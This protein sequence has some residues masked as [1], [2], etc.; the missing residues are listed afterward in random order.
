MSLVEL[1][2]HARQQSPPSEFKYFNRLASA[3]DPVAASIFL[4]IMQDVF[5]QQLE[6]T[7]EER[8]GIK[9]KSQEEL[10]SFFAVVL[11]AAEAENSP[12]EIIERIKQG[13]D[14]EIG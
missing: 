4:Q 1:F 14:K 7:I 3:A 9:R 10:V 6:G 8:K 12:A 5:V 11:G 2:E 13:D